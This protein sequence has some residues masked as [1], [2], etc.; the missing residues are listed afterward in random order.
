MIMLVLTEV[1]RLEHAQALLVKPAG[2]KLS[3]TWEKRRL[4]HIF[5]LESKPVSHN[6]RLVF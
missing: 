5:G 3:L 6:K 1:C 4:K 2:V